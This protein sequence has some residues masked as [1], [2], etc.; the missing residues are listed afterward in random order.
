M[1]KHSDVYE[2]Q[3]ARTKQR[4]RISLSPFVLCLAAVLGAILISETVIL[5]AHM[6]QTVLPGWGTMHPTTLVISYVLGGSLIMQNLSW[7]RDQPANSRVLYGAAAL[8]VLLI[9]RLADLQGRPIAGTLPLIGSLTDPRHVSLVSLIGSGAL[10]VVPLLKPASW[11][12]AWAVL[13]LCITVFGMAFSQLAQ[14]SIPLKNQVFLALNLSESLV[15]LCLTALALNVSAARPLLYHPK[16]PRTNLLMWGLFVTICLLLVLDLTSLT[17]STFQMP[18]FVVSSLLLC[19]V[20]EKGFRPLERQVIA[21]G[22]TPSLQSAGSAIQ[23]NDT[24]SQKAHAP[25]SFAPLPRLLRPNQWFTFQADTAQRLWPLACVLFAL[26]MVSETRFSLF[27]HWF[28]ELWWG[29]AVLAYALVLHPLKRWPLVLLTG[30]CAMG[31]ARISMGHPFDFTVIN[32]GFDGIE[33]A[34]I[35]GIARLVFDIKLSG[36]TFQSCDVNPLAVASLIVAILFT[37]LTVSLLAGATLHTLARQNLGPTVRARWLSNVLGFVQVAP[38]AAGLI[39]QMHFGMTRLEMAALPGLLMTLMLAFLAFVCAYFPVEYFGISHSL[40]VA[41]SMTLLIA[42]VALP[43]ILQI[44]AAHAVVS[45]ALLIGAG[46]VDHR[47]YVEAAFLVLLTSSLVFIAGAYK[48][49]RQRDRLYRTA[50]LENSP[51]MIVTLDSQFRITSASDQ[52]CRYLG[53]KRRELIGLF[54]SENGFLSLPDTSQTNMRAFMRHTPETDFTLELDIRQRSGALRMVLAAVRKNTNPGLPYAYLVQLTDITEMNRNSR[55]YKMTLE[56]GPALLL[57]QDARRL[58]LNVAPALCDSLGYDRADLIGHDIADLTSP[59]TRSFVDQMRALGDDVTPPGN[60]VLELTTKSGKIRK[61][62]AQRRIIDPNAQGDQPKYVILLTDVTELEAQRSLTETLLNRNAAIVLSQDRDW[63]LLSV[64]DAWSAHFGYTR[65]ETLGR[66][67]I[68]F[69]PAEDQ[70]L[71]KSF[72]RHLLANTR[73]KETISN[74]LTL[75]TKSGEPRIVELRSVIEE[76]E[77]RWLNIIMVIDITDI[78]VARQKLE[79]LVDH[80]ELTG[81]YSRRGF[82]SRFADRKRRQDVDVFLIDVDHFKSVNDA[83]GHETGDE[84][85]RKVA[86]VLKDKTRAHGCASRIGGEEFAIIRTATQGCPNRK[87]AEDLA[88]A[89]SE[90]AVTTASGPVTRTVSIG[91]ARLTQDMRLEDGMNWA[92]WA[93]REA[94]EGGRNRIVIA[95]EGFSQKLRDDGKLTTHRDIISA[96]EAGEINKYVQPIW[97]VTRAEI[98]GFEALMRWQR[99]SG[100]VVLPRQFLPQLQNV[101]LAEEYAHI[102]SRIRRSLLNT[103][104]ACPGT[105]ICFNTRLESL[106]FQGAA[107]AILREFEPLCEL[108]HSIVLEIGEQAITDRIDMDQVMVEIAILRARGIRVA[109]DDFGKEGSNLNRLTHLPIDIVKIDKSLI[110]RIVIDRRSREALRSI[111]RLAEA[112]EFEVIAEGVET[113]AQR[114]MLL[115]LGLHLHQ[116]FLYARPMSAEAAN[117]LYATHKSKDQPS[118]DLISTF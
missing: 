82:N 91:V 29:N 113:E 18:F 47:T 88:R 84:L 61:M 4:W 106:G 104:M 95:D 8:L 21:A 13:A 111:A 44:G 102:P 33:A 115:D 93:L 26:S 3:L 94:K 42:T 64:S 63:R 56:E 86:G 79:H 62:T 5:L 76:N 27:L 116:G 31:L 30:V 22:L 1:K 117:A 54:A 15:L 99:A 92:D 51:T 83:Y 10:F 41:V 35:A 2:A 48:Q 74:T 12:R 46:L 7:D 78:S 49:L 85:L 16:T 100:E 14:Q 32:M 68:D 89:I 59:N 60:K 34:L 50:L 37:V 73:D 24:A 9:L 36:R 28:P 112:L 38:I 45:T 69:M 39:W 23:N 70:A 65:E 80:D 20:C 40:S 58:T 105:Y 96:L 114:D 66:D 118:Q 19:F 53:V 11:F 57:V 101:V 108:S 109:L 98:V 71:S 72:R 25:L 87:F 107:Q 110:D 97:D 43:S 75:L 103:L 6:P 55:L 81:L 90:T 67:L 17:L 52:V 77:D